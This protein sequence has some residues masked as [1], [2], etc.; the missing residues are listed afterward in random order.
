[1]LDDFHLGQQV[2]ETRLGAAAA[3]PESKAVFYQNVWSPRYIDAPILRDRYVGGNLVLPARVFYLA[4]ANYNVTGLVK[5]NSGTTD[6][7]VV[8][9]YAYTPYGI[10]TFCDASWTDVGNSA[11]G[12]TTLYT[13]R[14][15]D[16]LTSLY[17]YRA[18][19]YDAALERFVSRDPAE[20]S[21]NLYEYCGDNPVIYVDPTGL[22]YTVTPDISTPQVHITENS[23][24]DEPY[25]CP[26]PGRWGTRHHGTI[27]G[28]IDVKAGVTGK[29]TN[30]FAKAITIGTIGVVDLNVSAGWSASVEATSAFSINVDYITGCKLKTLLGI[31]AKSCSTVTVTATASGWVDVTAKVAKTGFEAGGKITG[32]IT[33]SGEVCVSAAGVTTSG[34]HI[35]SSG[36]HASAYAKWVVNG[37][38]K[39]EWDKEL[40]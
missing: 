37:E 17:Y 30:L 19:Y 13:G 33:L 12:N 35:D 38:T 34:W 36:V 39:N 11:N 40:F 5:Y 6:W 26:C 16:A 23:V 14:T 8:E 4:D 27:K 22:I 18:R 25:K 28:N 20:S 15:L 32:S 29:Y 2:I 3:A 10:A 1:V 24:T 9:R 21:P 31:Q 7:E